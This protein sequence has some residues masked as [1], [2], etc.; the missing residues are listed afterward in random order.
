MKKIIFTILGLFF[1]INLYSQSINNIN[2][3]DYKL[4]SQ[5]TS[6][7]VDEIKNNKQINI[8]QENNNIYVLGWSKNGK[9]AFINN[10]YVDGRGGKDLFFVIQD[11]IDD[12]NVYYKKIKWYD[13]DNYG[14]NPEM[15]QTFE[16]CILSNSKEFN[17]E[18]RKNNI[19]IK[20][21]QVEMLPA[22]DKNENKI[23]FQI[24]NVNKYAGEYNLMHMDYEIRAVKN[25][26]Y[27]IL[28]KIINKTCD[29]VMPTGYI[30]SP[31]EDRI[32]LIV[33]DAEHVFE[34]DEVFINFYGCSLNSG[35][36]MER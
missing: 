6:F 26:K 21:V 17:N 18:L 29:F 28:G 15:A 25:G 22:F 13:N 8:Y 3:E 4:N 20:P 36:T 11:L 33:A 9:I 10:K 30:K 16:Q 1:T 32:A 2:I 19:I 23:I 34:G 12:I 7:L 24:S 14:E 31:Y 27:K 35:Y 5:I